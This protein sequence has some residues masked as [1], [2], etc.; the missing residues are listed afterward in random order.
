MKKQGS[1]KNKKNKKT[2]DRAPK[3]RDLS[4]R[5]DPRGGFG[6]IGPPPPPPVGQY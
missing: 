1:K 2:M 6:R 5:K 3:L 4:S